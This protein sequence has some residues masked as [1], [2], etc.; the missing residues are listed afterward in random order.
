MTRRQR[1]GQLGWTCA[2][3]FAIFAA[4]GVAQENNAQSMALIPAGIFVMGDSFDEGEDMEQP[5][6]EVELDAFRMDRY[7]VTKAL[8]DKVHDW[9]IRNGYEFDHPGRG[10]EKDHPVVEVSWHDALKWCNAR[11]EMQGRTP[12]YYTDAD[13]SEVYRSGAVELSNDG[14]RWDAGYRL[15]TEAEWERAAGGDGDRRRFPWGDTIDHERANYWA[16]SRAHAYDA[17]GQARWT[18]HP[19]YEDGPHPYTSPVGSFEAGPHGLHDMAGNVWEWCWDWYAPYSGKKE[20]NPRGPDSGWARVIR[21]GGWN[22]GAHNCRV[23]SRY[24]NW[25]GRGGQSLGFRTVLPEESK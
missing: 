1:Q 21:G 16:N 4:Q 8:W 17:S 18:Y 25:P 12:A 2:M 6:R 20:S 7:P 3:V 24:G 10:K 14:V 11:S 15:P 23:A 9:A 22:A 5:V 13:Q 19:D